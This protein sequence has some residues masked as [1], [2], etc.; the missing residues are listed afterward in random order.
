MHTSHFEFCL[1][2]H[3]AC[4]P[5]TYGENCAK[6]CACGVGASDCDVI[7]GCVCRSGWIGERCDQD[8]DECQTVQTKN[9]CLAQN[10]RCVNHQGGYACRCA[11]GF[12]RNAS[13][14]CAGKHFAYLFT[15][16]SV[17]SF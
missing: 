2:F 13:N 3:Q 15:M 6:S 1:S 17:P 14:V 16:V 8:I 12:T 4:P 10:A 5:E 9:E 7:A 11:P